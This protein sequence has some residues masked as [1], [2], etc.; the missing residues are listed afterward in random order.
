MRVATILREPMIIQRDGNRS[1][2]NKR[3]SAMLDEV[4]C[5]PPRPS[6]IRTSSRAGSGS[7]SGSPG[8]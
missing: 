2:Q 4:D 3:V 8:R 6:G 7:G 5:R 1:S